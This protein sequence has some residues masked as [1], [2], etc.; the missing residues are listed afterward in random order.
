MTGLTIKSPKIGV[1][2]KFFPRSSQCS[3]QSGSDQVKSARH[4]VKEYIGEPDRVFHP[5]PLWLGEI[6][7]AADV[8]IG[9]RCSKKPRAKR[10]SELAGAAAHNPAHGWTLSNA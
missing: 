6:V 7:E 1:D 8:V 9:L 10:V 4:A 5:K 2:R 3:L